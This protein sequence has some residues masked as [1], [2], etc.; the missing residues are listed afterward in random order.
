MMA[1]QERQTVFIVVSLLV[2]A[3][4]ILAACGGGVEPAAPTIAPADQEAASEGEAVEEE[5][6]EGDEHAEAEHGHDEE[7]GEEHEEEIE[8][9]MDEHS[10]EEHM[11]G[12]HDV[13]EEASAVENP[14]EASEESVETGRSLYAENCA[15]CH[16]ETG[17]GDGPTAAALDPAPADLHADHVQELTDGGLF[18]IINHGRLE[19]AMP[20][21]EGTLEEGEI[22]H[23]VNFLRTFQ[24]Q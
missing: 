21:W 22:W 9:H 11:E 12:A 4:M 10:P 2:M 19:A 7:E 18:Y 23:V 13:P 16:G 14:I 6:E 24:G 15:V 17:E 20:A 8:E 3:T 5:H 1:T